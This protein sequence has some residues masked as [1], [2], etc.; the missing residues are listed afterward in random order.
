M[1]L[2][3]LTSCGGKKDDEESSEEFVASDYGAFLGRIDNDVTNF[4]KYKYISCELNEFSDTN[5]KRLT[6]KGTNFLAYLNVG[7]LE[8]YRD[9][10]EDFESITFLD[11]EDWPDERWIDVSNTTWQ[12]YLINTIAKDFKDRGAY[13]V[14][15]DNVDVY[16]IAKEEGK[17]YS[18][19][20]TGIKNI[21][22][23]VANLGLKVMINGGSEFLDDMNDQNDGIFSSIWAYHQEEVFSLIT[24]YE[25]DEFG[26]QEQEDSEYYQKIANIMKNKGK[27]VFFLEYTKDDNLIKKIKDYCESK[28]YYYFIASKVNLE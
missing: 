6:E 2:P 5:I 7:S 1:L 12:N 16:T 11:Y 8:E 15:M 27:E 4:N 23:G 28:N 20:A 22:K 24:D 13:G 18:S 19:F 3:L 10:Y 17:N 25:E 21:I 14:Y 9:Y 26:T